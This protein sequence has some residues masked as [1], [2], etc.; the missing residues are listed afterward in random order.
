MSGFFFSSILFCTI[1]P[2]YYLFSLITSSLP[3]WL[4]SIHCL[5]RGSSLSFCILSSLWLW[6]SG[7]H[8]GIFFF[9][10]TFTSFLKTYFFSV[11]YVQLSLTFTL[12]ECLYFLIVLS[13]QHIYTHTH[14]HIE[15][16]SHISRVQLFATL[17]LYP[18]RLLCPWDSPGRDTGVGCHVLRQRIFP[19]QGQNLHP[20]C[21]VTP[22]LQA[23]S[24]LLS[25]LETLYI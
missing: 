15:V 20:A 9:M 23:D 3:H 21:P 5:L 16:L 2:L 13:F 6:L 22:A 24:L 1:F 10:L 4:L 8:W 18:T 14:I 11:S 12:I 25:H 17:E 19:A 7:E